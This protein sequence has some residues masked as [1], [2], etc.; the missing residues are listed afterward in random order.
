MPDLFYLLD[1]VMAN[2]ATSNSRN[3]LTYMTQLLKNSHSLEKSFIFKFR[4]K[5]K[6]YDF[7]PSTIRSK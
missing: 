1:E 3:K 4:I 2:A 5:I 7:S 6:S